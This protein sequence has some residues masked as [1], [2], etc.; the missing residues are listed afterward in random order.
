MK[1][2]TED[3]KGRC[4][5]ELTGTFQTPLL[6]MGWLEE[7]GAAAAQ[8]LLFGVTKKIYWLKT[9]QHELSPGCDSAVRLAEEN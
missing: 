5:C 3:V 1:G 6:Q 2:K 7:C 4:S 9:C 8:M